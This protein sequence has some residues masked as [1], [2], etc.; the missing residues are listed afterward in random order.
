MDSFLVE[1]KFLS[2]IDHP[3]VVKLLGIACPYDNELN[4][5]MVSKAMRGFALASNLTLVSG[6][7]GTWKSKRHHCCKVEKSYFRVEDQTSH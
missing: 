7:H 1:I 5:I 4:I 2:S 3:N 6:T